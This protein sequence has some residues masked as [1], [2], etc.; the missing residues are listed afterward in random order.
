MKASFEVLLKLYPRLQGVTQDTFSSY[1]HTHSGLLCKLLQDF[2]FFK[3]QQNLL[4]ILPLKTNDEEYEKVDTR[5]EYEEENVK[6]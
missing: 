4:P 2:T 3:K 5:A 6:L 1:S